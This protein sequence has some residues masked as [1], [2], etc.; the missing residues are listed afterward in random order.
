MAVLYRET[1]PL[2][3]LLLVLDTGWLWLWGWLRR[4]L[5][6]L[7]L[8]LLYL[9]LRLLHLRLRLVRL[10]LLSELLAWLSLG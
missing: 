8:R 7:C 2:G 6:Y 5:L 9:C 10:R 4:R 3:G 1:L